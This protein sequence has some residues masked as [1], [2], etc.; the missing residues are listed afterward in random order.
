MQGTV[1]LLIHQMY[2]MHLRMSELKGVI[3][4]V[5]VQSHASVVSQY[6]FGQDNSLLKDEG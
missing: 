5:I 6:S 3:Q 4:A 2:T 1:P